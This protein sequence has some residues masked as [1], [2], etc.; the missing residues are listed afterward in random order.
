MTDQTNARTMALAKLI[1]S[2]SEALEASE[3]QQCEK[4]L[5]QSARECRMILLAERQAAR[6]KELD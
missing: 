2:A 6:E 1:L 4:L 3:W 5:Y